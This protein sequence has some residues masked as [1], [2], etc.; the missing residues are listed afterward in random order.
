M[1]QMLNKNKR[2]VVAM[3]GG[4]DSSVATFL[5]KKQGYDVVGIFLKF[6]QPPEKLY[7]EKKEN[8][9]CD[10]NSLNTARRVAEILKMPFYVIDLS[11]EFKKK[12]VDYYLKE[13]EDGRTPN[14]CVFCNK[15]IKF[16]LLWQKALGLD[17]S[18]L[19]TGHYARLC[20]AKSQIPNPKSQIL[21]A[22][23]A[24]YFLSRAKDETK[25]QSYFLWDIDKKI[26][27]HLIF[28]LG[29]LNKKE[30]R[31]IARKA[32]LPV[33]NKKDSQGVCFIPDGDN[34][35]F[36]FFFSKKLSKPGE[37]VDKYSNVL[38]YHKGLVSYTIGQREGLGDE[39]AGNWSRANKK[40]T[41]PP[42]LY[43]KKL[44]IKKN[45]LIVA[46]NRE[47]FSRGLLVKNINIFD[48]ESFEKHKL[49][50]VQ[51]RG[52]HK[53]EECKILKRRNRKEVSLKFSKSIRAIT[54]GQ[55]AVFYDKKGQ[56]LGGGII[57]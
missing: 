5:L 34:K 16:G 19:A 49:I 48:E 6:W 9:C 46:E 51:I 32:K 56:V 42:P 41:S 30:V 23:T 15:F 33:Y 17:A 45:R 40:K 26:I 7:R 36:L 55:S 39:I 52:G 29:D 57:C 25:D 53:A 28:P 8:L 20:R 27:P 37:I 12:I 18:F 22:H 50:Y 38:G 13:Y 24:Q 4:V 14:P 31:D 35:R 43:V 10:L 1:S 47:I 3:S 11:H 54:P 44:D 21:G 2:V